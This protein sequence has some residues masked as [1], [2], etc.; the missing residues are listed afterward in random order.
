MKRIIIISA[1][2]LVVI[3]AV[4]ITW[5]MV[6][7]Q[8]AAPR[9]ITAQVSRGDIQA[10]IQET[11]TVNPVNEVQVGTQVSGTIANLYVDYNSIVHKGQVLATLDPTSFQAAETQA[12]AGV[13]QAEANASATQATEAQM[14]ASAQSAAANSRKAQA[15]LALAQSTR[16]RDQELIAQGYISQSQADTD[17]ASLRSAQADVAAALMAENAAKAQQNAASHQAAASSAQVAS[18]QGNLQVANYNLN[19]TTITSPIDGIIVSRAVSV[20]QTVAASFQTPTLFVIAT[21]LKDMQVD[22]SVSEADVGELADGQ[23]ASITVPAYPNTTFQGTVQQV[24]VNPTT[25]QNVVTYDTVVAIHDE[26]ARLK[27]GMTANVTINVAT[28]KNVLTV[29]IAAL[30]Y[31]PRTS[32]A[33][34][35][36][37]GGPVGFGAAANQ[38]TPPP[39]AGAPGSRVVV[40]K[41][42]QR[43]PAPVQ[44]VIGMSDGANFEVRSGDLK[45]GDRVITGQLQARQTTTTNPLGGGR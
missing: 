20:G 2:V 15:A 23:S 39:V 27:P 3:I 18:A 1:I 26:S 33:P 21:T 28:R 38:A 36:A 9:F 5:R 10:T 22:V 37:P 14:A 42:A 40:W 17:V 12:Q 8:K 30:L 7:A 4:I 25:I 19:R 31:K 35:P 16:T 6:S 34:T 44:I 24:R 32:A 13:A 11:G 45:E 29:P 41:L 43:K